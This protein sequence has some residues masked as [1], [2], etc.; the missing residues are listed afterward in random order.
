MFDG[1]VCQFEL[2]PKEQS[3]RAS[4]PS[5]TSLRKGIGAVG[6]SPALNGGDGPVA[7]EAYD[8]NEYADREIID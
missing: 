8:G 2:S 7:T 5:I 6:L 3:K 1:D 4:Y